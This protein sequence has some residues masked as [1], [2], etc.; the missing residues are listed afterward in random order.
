VSAPQAQS[1]PLRI[2]HVFRAPVGGLFRHV[3]DLARAQIA[4]GHAVGLVCA[5]D[6]GGLG[7][8][9]SLTALAPLCALGVTRLPMSRLPG[10][11]DLQTAWRVAGLAQK[12]KPNVLHGHGAKGGLYSRLPALLGASK[13]AARVYTP[14]GGSFHYGPGTLAHHAFMATERKLARVTDAFTFESAFVASLFAAY[15]GP[16]PGLQRVIHNGL[17]EQDFE[18]VA[19]APEPADFL[20]LGELRHLKG[21]DTLLEAAALLR[22]ASGYEP[23]LA[24][25]GEGPDRAALT[26]LAQRLKLTRTQFL[27]ARPAREAFSLAPVMVVASRAESL[28]YVVMEAA[29][30][31]RGLIATRVGGIAEILGPFADTL[32]APGDPR[33]LADAMTRSL[34]EPPEAR[35]RR[36]DAICAHVAQHM[37][38]ARMAQAIEDTYHRALGQER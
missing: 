20:H 3:M 32:I 17:R 18:P 12:L 10:L 16:A 35:R 13:A 26:A 31:R 24:L 25:V 14:H 28:P 36:A 7:A 29:A 9:H 38:I 6:L 23:S 5:A 4:A 19:L 8:D 21:V 30:A 33:L 37:T 15:V 1:P 34:A 2:L 11:S 27:S 22:D